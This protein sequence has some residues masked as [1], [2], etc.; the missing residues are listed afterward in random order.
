[1]LGLHQ[2]KRPRG[3]RVFCFQHVQHA[4]PSEAELAVPRIKVM[5]PTEVTK[6]EQ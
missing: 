5:P 3:Y 4:G 1:M 6:L 2:S